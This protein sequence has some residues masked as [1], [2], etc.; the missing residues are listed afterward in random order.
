MA[1]T[2]G[3]TT[4]TDKIKL[5]DMGTT[6]LVEYVVNGPRRLLGARRGRAACVIALRYKTFA[7]I[8]A[9]YRAVNAKV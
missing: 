5:A 9:F 8:N 3:M 2:Y 4:N 7:A 6:G 1:Y